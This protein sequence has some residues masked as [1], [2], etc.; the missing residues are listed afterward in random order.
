[1]CG[2]HLV[3]GSN[4]NP[5]MV[6]RARVAYS[7]DQNELQGRVGNGEVGVPVPHL[8]RFGG[9]QLGIELDRGVEIRHIEGQLHSGHGALLIYS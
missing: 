5:E 2:R 4:L 3:G 1:M 9:E 8:G 6:E 7:L